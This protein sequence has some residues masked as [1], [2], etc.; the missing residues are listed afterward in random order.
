MMSPAGASILM[1]SA[2]RSPRIWVASGPR[3]TV[4]RS[5]ILMPASGPGL[6]AILWSSI[7]RHQ[8][9]SCRAISDDGSVAGQQ[10]EVLGTRLRDQHAVERI[11]MQ[12][13]QRDQCLAMVGQHR[14]QIEAVGNRQ[15]ALVLS[16]A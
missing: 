12:S 8:V 5:R 11:A 9:G 1:T 4:V 13:R 15:E 7:E 14:K 10:G 3:T 2:P 16:D 6:R